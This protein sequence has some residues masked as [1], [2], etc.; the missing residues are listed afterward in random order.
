MSTE[1]LE[2]IKYFSIALVTFLATYFFNYFFRFKPR[3]Y[4]SMDHKVLYNQRND[5][6]Q[7]FTFN[8]T[9]ELMVKNNSKY[10]AEDITIIFPKGCE[11]SDVSSDK[12]FKRNNHIESYQELKFETNKLVVANYEDVVHVSYK[13][14]V[15]V[16]TPGTKMQNPPEYFK[17]KALKHILLI[18]KYRSEK[19]KN[20]YTLYENNN[21]EQRNKIFA[22]NPALLLNNRFLRHIV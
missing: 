21:G 4:V 20:F 9:C 1:T 2:T 15:R 17:P 10:T 8:Y 14:G 11:I 13:D 16:I 19:N 5:N 18:L 12:I 6:Y 7:R 3:L 22:Y